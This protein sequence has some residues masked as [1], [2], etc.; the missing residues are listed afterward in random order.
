MERDIEDREKAE[1]AAS[2]KVEAEE[3][4]RQSDVRKKKPKKVG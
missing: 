3:F 2:R 1:E 4:G